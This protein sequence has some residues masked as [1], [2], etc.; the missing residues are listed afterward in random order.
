MG[1]IPFVV[2][3]YQRGFLVYQT[4]IL[5]LNRLYKISADGVF[6]IDNRTPSHLVSNS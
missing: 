2:L 4:R 1:I 6:D 3:L 5:N